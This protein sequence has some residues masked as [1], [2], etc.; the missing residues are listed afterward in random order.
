MLKRIT[1]VT[2]LLVTAAA[3]ISMIPAMAADV[4][5][6]DTEEGTIYGAKSLGRGSY[7]IDGE[8][9]GKDDAV[10]Y[11]AD[12]KYTQLEDAGAGDE[13]G[14]IYKDKYLDFNNGDYYIDITTGKKI[15]DKV[16]DDINS[17][18]A[19]ALRKK[20][21]KDN[22]GRFLESS[23][24]G[25][26]IQP[27]KIKGN[28]KTDIWGATGKWREFQY[29]LKTKYQFQG[30]LKDIIYTDES[31]N[32]V[33]ADYNVGNVGV[34]FTTA[35][36]VTIKNTKDTY[37][38]TVGGVDYTLKAQIINDATR[39]ED[40][41]Y[42]TRSAKLTI[43]KKLK[44]DPDVDASYA[45]VTDQVFFGSKAKH[46]KAPVINSSDNSVTVLQ[47]ISKAQAS[48]DVDGIK[49][50][51]NVGTYFVTDDKGNQ[52]H[53]FGLFDFSKLPSPGNIPFGLITGSP[54]GIA[55]HCFDSVEKKYYAQTINFKAENGYYYT[56]VSDYDD[57]GADAWGIGGG[58]LYSVGSGYVK[59]WNNKD[60]KFD[61]LYK[62]DG[63]FD[64]F[65][66]A[67][68]ASV[69]AWNENDKVY[70]LIFNKPSE[71]TDT[72]K[73][74]TPAVVATGWV[75]AA[76]GTWNYVKT[77]GTKAT[78]WLQDGSIWY[79]LNTAGVMQTGWINDNGT[80]YYC[81]VSGAMLANTTVD[82]YVL[83]ANGA[84]IV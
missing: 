24:E 80:W 53:I 17:D 37:D 18:V 44:T 54:D 5:K 71:N 40:A 26:H 67:Y 47:R 76:D 29:D 32:Y 66:V 73:T 23:Y 38:V 13:I 31:G 56:D 1:K 57:T 46:Y 28:D 63:S 74:T 65:S 9:N 25:N 8:I 75:K 51:K 20:I 15:D 39:D 82:G 84:W 16:L 48:G 50:A 70:S 52:A 34:Y 62:V 77:D 45:N 81:N 3:V 83:G 4:K 72:T 33:D 6:Y 68:D 30:K 58:N 7:I 36:G 10:Y 59:K 19:D 78:G 55:S 35:A 60:S 22:D 43:W 69:V 41:D 14:D 12:G 64:K 21:K 42:I 2:S 49:Y 11:L 27:D 61:K 79:Y